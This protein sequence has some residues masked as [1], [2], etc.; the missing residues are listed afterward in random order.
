MQLERCAATFARA[1]NYAVCGAAIPPCNWIDVDGAQ[2][3]INSPQKIGQAIRLLDHRQG[4]FGFEPPRRRVD[5]ISRRCVAS[6]SD[7][8]V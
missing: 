1:Q 5:P 6:E 3:L 4:S 7:V 2:P 8:A